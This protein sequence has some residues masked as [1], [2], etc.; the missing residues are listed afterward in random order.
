MIQ[1]A[2]GART[3]TLA[4]WGLLQSNCL[5]IKAEE[6]QELKARQESTLRRRLREAREA[7][8]QTPAQLDKTSGETTKPL[9]RRLPQAKARK[10]KEEAAK[11]SS[12]QSTDLPDYLRTVSSS[13]SITPTDEAVPDV[14]G[15]SDT[16]NVEEL[17]K[18]D[19]FTRK[20]SK[21]CW[22]T[23]KGSGRH[24][25]LPADGELILGRFDASFG[26]P[27]DIDLAYE[28]GDNQ[29]V[30]RRHVKITGHNGYHT[31]ED[32]GSRYGLFVNG[33]Q[34]KPGLSRHLKPGDR[35][36]IGGVQ[37]I[38]DQI[39]EYMQDLPKTTPVRHVLIVTPTGRKLR[40]DPPEDVIIGRSDR[41]IDNIP[42]IDLSQDGEAA[43]RV[44]RRHAIIHWR[45]DRPYL[46]DLGSGFGTRVNGKMVLIGHAVPLKPGDHIWLG[47]CVLAYDVE[48]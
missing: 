21:P 6:E 3:D 42:E 27:P 8:K 46:E 37:M 35:V 32:T 17:P 10:D 48:M 26:I 19:E 2:F 43:T 1:T 15:A 20:N 25:M 40:V 18:T 28:D 14:I 44:S 34:I 45:N 13:T 39:P 22:F 4:T 24:I 23:V 9:I 36:A 47:G 38:Y 12:K 7:K 41:F 30:S 5:L 11:A 31:I 29:T 16:N 33:E